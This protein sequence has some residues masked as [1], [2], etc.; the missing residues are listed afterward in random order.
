M[1]ISGGLYSVPSNY[2]DIIIGRT[3]LRTF[4]R[5]ISLYSRNVSY[6]TSLTLLLLS[7]SFLSSVEL[8][9]TFAEIMFPSTLEI[10]TVFNSYKFE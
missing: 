8:I 9:P 4:L 10:Q 6:G 1:I 3:D 2:M 7:S 5:I